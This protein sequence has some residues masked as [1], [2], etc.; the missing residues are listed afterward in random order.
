M[1]F[2]S[3]TKAPRRGK[4]P[5]TRVVELLDALDAAGVYASPTEDRPACADALIT[6]VNVTAAGKKAKLVDDDCGSGSGGAVLTAL[7]LIDEVVGKGPCAWPPPE[8][9]RRH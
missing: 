6:Y 2:R 1:L 5:P 3:C 8:R 7:K 4:L 9:S